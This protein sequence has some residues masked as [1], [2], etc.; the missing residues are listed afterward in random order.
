MHALLIL[1]YYGAVVAEL[2]GLMKSFESWRFNHVRREAN[3]DAH[4]VARSA[5]SME[6]ERISIGV[7]GSTV[8][9]SPNSYV[10]FLELD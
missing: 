1:I 8:S 4:N 6:G 2:R 5:S 10:I 3:V 9:P 7:F